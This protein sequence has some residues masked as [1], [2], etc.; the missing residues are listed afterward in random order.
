MQSPCQREKIRIISNLISRYH[1][2]IRRM[3]QECH[4]S[5]S[6]EQSIGYKRCQLQGLPLSRRIVSMCRCGTESRSARAPIR[7][8]SPPGGQAS[9]AARTKSQGHGLIFSCLMC[10]RRLPNRSYYRLTS[11]L[12][13]ASCTATPGIKRVEGTKSSRRRINC[14]PAASTLALSDSSIRTAVS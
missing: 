8:I 11:T 7:L 10:R 1:R 14:G 3:H 13:A 12:A 2:R 4:R 9:S 6:F 5:S